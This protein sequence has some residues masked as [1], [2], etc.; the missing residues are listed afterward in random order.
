ME[1]L[2]ERLKNAPLIAKVAL[3]ILL[4]S[5]PNI[6]TYTEETPVLEQ[7]REQ[8]VQERE[9][10]RML[11][12]KA[13]Q[14]AEKLVKLEV[15]LKNIRENLTQ[16]KKYL[17]DKIEMDEV[18]HTIARFCKRYSVDLDKFQPKAE[19][20]STSQARY[21]TKPIEVEL[22]GRFVD[23]ARFFDS[24]VHLQKIVHLRNV[25]LTKAGE[26]NQ[27]DNREEQIDLFRLSPEQRQRYA[28]SSTKVQASAEI[29]LFKSEA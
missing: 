8:A 28:E 3:A 16:A 12:I 26:Q 22:V 4:G 20:P 18:L 2:L 7:G 24:V 6:Y 11:Y 21:I 14:D 23:I 10:Q 13:K 19:E 25:R 29:V 9:R 15:T 17:P 1:E 5:L 27:D